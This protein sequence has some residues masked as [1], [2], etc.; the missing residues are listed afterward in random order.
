MSHT[1]LVIW[2]WSTKWDKSHLRQGKDGSWRWGQTLRDCRKGRGAQAACSPEAAAGSQASGPGEERVLKS[3]HTCAYDGAPRAPQPPSPAP[4]PPF[5]SPT[6]P[7]GS[8]PWSLLQPH[9]SSSTHSCQRG[10]PELENRII[11]ML[12]PYSFGNRPGGGSER[13]ASFQSS[14]PVSPPSGLTS[15]R[16]RGDAATAGSPPSAPCPGLWPLT[17]RK[18]RGRKGL[19]PHLPTLA[20]PGAACPFVP[21]TP[22]ADALGAFLPNVPTCFLPS[23]VRNSAE[24]R[25]PSHGWLVGPWRGLA[26]CFRA[27]ITSAGPPSSQDPGETGQGQAQGVS[28]NLEQLP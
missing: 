13:M 10:V 12:P 7:G 20:A 5:P 18:C 28:A 9:G 26:S 27:A 25:Q 24:S 22:P 11:K 3:R 8:S 15:L 4:A 6:L 14:R 17:Y 19:A 21:Y 1:G 23:E 2:G 16:S